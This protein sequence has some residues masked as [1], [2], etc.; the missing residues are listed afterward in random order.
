MIV[1]RSRT[2]QTVLIQTLLIN[3]ESSVQLHIYYTICG[4]CIPY[5]ERCIYN[6]RKRACIPRWGIWKDQYGVLILQLVAF[7]IYRYVEVTNA[8]VY[9]QLSYVYYPLLTVFFGVPFK[10]L[11]KFHQYLDFAYLLYC[12]LQALAP[13]LSA[14]WIACL[15][16][17]SR[18]IYY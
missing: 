1:V 10:E 13:L 17:L 9:T 18:L 8:Q 6:T 14:G 2:L 15:V 7:S 5:V 3:Q 4:S 11:Y 12:N 16:L